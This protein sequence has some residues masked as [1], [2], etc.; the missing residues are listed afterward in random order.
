MTANPAD[1][2]CR[3]RE[4]DI[5]CPHRDGVNLC[6]RPGQ[7]PFMRCMRFKLNPDKTIKVEAERLR[8]GAASKSNDRPPPFD[9]NKPSPH[10]PDPHAAWEEDVPSRE[11]VSRTPSFGEVPRARKPTEAKIIKK[12]GA[13]TRQ[14]PINKQNDESRR[15]E[16][17]RKGRQPND[18]GRNGTEHYQRPAGAATISG[19]VLQR[20]D[21]LL[22]EKIDWLWR[23]WLARGKLHV[24][25]GQKGAGKSTI[26]F[27][28][29]A[30]MTCGGKFPD[31]SRAPLGDVLIWSG[32]DDIKDTILPRMAVAGADRKRIYFI[33]GIVVN[34]VKRAFDPAIDMPALLDAIRDLPELCAIQIDPLVAASAG[35]SH[36][37]AETRRGLQP[38]VDVAT[39]RNICV[40][41]ITHFTK[42]TQGRDPIERITGSLAF[43]AIP[44]V[45]FG[46]AKFYEEVP[47]RL[48][49]I[50]SNIGPEGGGFEYLL[51]QDLVVDHDFT[52]QRIRW[53]KPLEGS[54]LDLLEN[55]QDK[56]KIAQGNELLDRLLADGPVAVSEIKDAAIANGISWPTMERA[57][58]EA[59]PAIIAEQAGKLRKRDLL[60][61]DSP[62]RGWYWY[63]ESVSGTTSEHT[64]I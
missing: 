25:G 42:G 13:A 2:C 36:K 7:V 3:T 15:A 40:L 5:L 60:P 24:L 63:K 49:R 8:E 12:A 46:A 22:M 47:R 45:V 21:E 17:E 31:G 61:T 34:G 62:S 10:F 64:I 58:T 27:D 56:L 35:D 52:A 50:A 29:L 28:L 14:S 23:G 4:G 53:G 9:P 48:A 43:G 33:N 44:R 20:G 30:Q 41:G 37:N 6:L 32:E 39:A 26:A 11:S 1:W 54:P 38:L 55:K 18:G 51:C 19:V 16:K 57:K 59:K